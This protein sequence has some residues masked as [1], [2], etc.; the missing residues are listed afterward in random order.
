M[1]VLA[2]MHVLWCMWEIK[3]QL[4]GVSF[5]SPPPLLLLRMGPQD[6]TQVIA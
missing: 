4:P 2:C 5:F 3:G 1:Y 6:Q